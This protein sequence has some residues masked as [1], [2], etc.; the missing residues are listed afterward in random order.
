MQ[1]RDLVDFLLDSLKILIVAL[2]I[3]IPIRAFLF[4]PFVV[5]GSS[6]EPNY[7]SSDYLI[8]DELSYNLRNPERGE[9]IV[10][11]YPLNPSLKYIKRI[12]A[13]PGETVEIKNGEIFIT[14]EKETFK[15]DESIYLSKERLN[16][17]SIN[18]NKEALKLEENQYFVMGDNRNYSSDSRKWGVVPFDNITGRVFMRFSIF[19]ILKNTISSESSY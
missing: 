11:K 8:I 6:M 15:I 9:V 7:F 2:L 18:N 3:I 13:L 5:K 1:L 17:W 16:S 10:F 12:I 19:E 14:K 4:Q